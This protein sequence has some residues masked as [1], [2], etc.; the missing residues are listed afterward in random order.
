VSGQLGANTID[1]TQGVEKA[2]ADLRPVV[3]KEGAEMRADCSAPRILI[4][5]STRNVQRSLLLGGVLVVVLFLFLRSA[6]SH[7]FMRGDPLSLGCGR[8]AERARRDAQR[9]D[10]GGLGDRNRRRLSTMR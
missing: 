3:E 7:D 2:L 1:V 10:P 5:I 4:G 6:H 9:D 8:R